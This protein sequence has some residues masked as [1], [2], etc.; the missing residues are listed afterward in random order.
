[1]LSPTSFTLQLSIFL[2][3]K[4]AQESAALYNIQVD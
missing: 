1:M 2:Y 4:L 3:L